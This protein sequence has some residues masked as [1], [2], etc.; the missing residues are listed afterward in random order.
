MT[1]IIFLAIIAT[2]TLVLYFAT[3]RMAQFGATPKGERL[4]RIL[5]SPNYDGTSFVN[6]H[7]VVL[8]FSFS[9]YMTMFKRLIFGDEQRNPDINI[10]V[11]RLTTADFSNADKDQLYVTWMGHSSVLLELDGRRILTDPVWS[12]R[13]SPI[14][15]MGPS[16]FHPIPIELEQLPDIDIVIISHDHYDHLDK[17]AVQFLAN[18]G[19]TFLTTLG[20]GAHLESWAIDPKQIVE[21][22]WWD[23]YKLDDSLTIA[24]TP[25]Q[26]FSGRSWFGKRNQSLWSTWAIVGSKQRVFFCGDTGEMPEFEDIGQ[27][28]G[29]FD[30]TLMKIGAYGENWPDIHLTPEQTIRLHQKLQG[31]LLVPIHWGSFNLAL[32][33]WD[34]PI[35]QLVAQSNQA[36]INYVTP[37]PGQRFNLDAL[38]RVD[39]WWEKKE[40]L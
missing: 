18:K 40:P 10:P 4:E 20:V 9:D 15:F 36:H 3:D 39:R 34:E 13:T 17:D 37:Y 25:A 27:K 6:Q 14:S 33:S 21:L 5:K 8:S 23:E 26:H 1:L 22:D 12:E 29:P 32:H 16:R 31:K 19:V 35:R 7:N 2:G 28:Y 38:P 11:N 30:L 24:C